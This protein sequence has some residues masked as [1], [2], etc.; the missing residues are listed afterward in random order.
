MKCKWMLIHTV[1][2]VKTPKEP[3]EEVA[4]STVTPEQR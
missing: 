2:W 1:F 4:H 3:M